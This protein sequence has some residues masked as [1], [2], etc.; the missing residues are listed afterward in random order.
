MLYTCQ[1]C[2]SPAPLLRSFC[3][4]KIRSICQ[5]R[6]L[7]PRI[8]RHNNIKMYSNYNRV[9]FDIPFHEK[10]EAKGMGARWDNDRRCWYAP[11]AEC[12]EALMT[13]WRRHGQKVYFDIPFHAKDKAKEMGARWDSERKSWYA[14]DEDITDALA[15]QWLERNERLD[16]RYIPGED[17]SFGGG[18]HIDLIPE[19][20]WGTN[21]RSLVST[22]GWDVLRRFVYARANY[23]CECCDIEVR[24]GMHCHERFAYDMRRGTQTLKR[25]MALCEDCHESTHMG[26]AEVNGNGDR[27]L[28]HLAIVRQVSFDQALSERQRAF[29]LWAYR[30][31]HSWTCDISILHGI[32]S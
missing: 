6:G 2:H 1:Q 9:Y 7:R 31:Q 27:A 14:P 32:V 24:N 13:R 12:K 3:V 16:I 29:E 30:S 22:H 4:L 25:L 20:A 26:L 19:P 5:L 28:R 8:L 10:D 21:V 23:H 18:L 15:T 17:R 11:D